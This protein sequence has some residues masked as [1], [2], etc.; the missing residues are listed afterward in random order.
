MGFPNMRQPKPSGF[1]PINLDCTGDKDRY[2]MSDY[3]YLWIGDD[4]QCFGVVPDHALLRL[5]NRINDI[6][7]ER[8][9]NERS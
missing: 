1:R 2:I 4:I 9:R 3:D 7:K 8:K 6:L 5:R